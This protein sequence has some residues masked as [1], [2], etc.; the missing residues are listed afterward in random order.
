MGNAVDAIDWANYNY[1]SNCENT[2]VLDY[3]KI[4]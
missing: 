1:S 3:H 2:L 4:E